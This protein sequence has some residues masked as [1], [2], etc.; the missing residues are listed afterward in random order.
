MRWRMF[1]N[2]MGMTVEGCQRLEVRGI[3]LRKRSGVQVKLVLVS[4][5]ENNV[6]GY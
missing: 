6:R 4:R 3:W 2:A 5:G 1:R